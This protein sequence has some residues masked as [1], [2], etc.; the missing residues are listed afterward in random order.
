MSTFNTFLAS[1]GYPVT[2]IMAMPDAIEYLINEGR[3]DLIHDMLASPDNDEVIN[4]KPEFVSR[5]LKPVKFKVSSAGAALF[6]ESNRV[7]T[8]YV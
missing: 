3:T 5:P 8:R 6:P 4:P 1:V 2:K 7:V